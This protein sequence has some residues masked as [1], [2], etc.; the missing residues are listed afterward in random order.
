MRRCW[1]KIIETQD[2]TTSVLVLVLVLYFSL[3]YLNPSCLNH[4]FF[5]QIR[6]LLL[7]L[8]PNLSLILSQSCFLFCFLCLNLL[9][10][11]LKSTT[12][13]SSCFKPL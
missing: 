4:F 10:L 6:P 1:M 5:Q 8:R 11:P 3:T 13:A 2:K 9:Y 7:I 12:A